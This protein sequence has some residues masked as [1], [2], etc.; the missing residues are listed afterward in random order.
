MMKRL[1]L[2]STLLLITSLSYAAVPCSMARLNP[3]LQIMAQR[4]QLM[5]EVAAYKFVH[6]LPIYDA[7]QDLTILQHVNGI[8]KDKGFDP[9]SLLIFA[10]IQMDMSK[11]IETYW[12]HYWQTHPNDRPNPRRVESSMKMRLQL[13]S[14][15]HK[16]YPAIKEALPYYHGCTL[17]QLTMA[18]NHNFSRIAG[19]PHNPDYA[20]IYLSAL[21][22][23]HNVGSYAR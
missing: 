4:A 2:L 16:L 18:F 11:Y 7:K 17:P 13:I 23:I 8:A 22:N 15:G 1:L 9:Q 5:H 21:K 19:V 10:Q 3:S 6:N 14:I 12:I 20:A